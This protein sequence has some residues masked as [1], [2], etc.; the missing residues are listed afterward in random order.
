MLEI[1]MS[2]MPIWDRDELTKKIAGMSN[3]KLRIEYLIEQLVEH[4]NGKRYLVV[5]DDIW[6]EEVWDQVHGA[7]PENR[8]GSRIL[9]TSRIKAV[10]SHASRTPDPYPLP[11]LNQEES[12]KL[13]RKKVFGN[14]QCPSELDTYGRQ[15]AE[16]CR[17]LPLSIVVL[18]GI[19]ANRER[20][21]REWSRSVDNV[22]QYLNESDC[23]K[24]LALSYTHLPR[25]LKL[26]FLY[27]GVYPKDYEIPVRQ[28][29][30]L[31]LA[32][33]FIPQTDGGEMEAKAEDK[34]LEKFIDQN[35][36]QVVSRRTDGR[37][38]TCV[39]PDLLLDI[40]ISQCKE[41]MFLEVFEDT[42]LSFPNK[43]RR[44]SLQG[45]TRGCISSKHA[46][47][48][49]FF[50]PDTYS[51][52]SNHLKWAIEHLE[53]VRVLNFEE[54]KL[55]SIPTK[56]EKL[57]FLRYLRI[58]SDELKDLPASICNLENLETLDMRGSKFLTRLP[59]GIWKLRRLRNLYMYGAV[60]LPNHL[61][62]NITAMENLR[63]LSTISPNQEIVR[64]IS[65]GQIFPNLTKFGIWF[66]SSENH[67]EL[68][69][70]FNCLQGLRSLQTLKIINCSEYPIL[71]TFP[72]TI[73]KITLRQSCLNVRRD[74]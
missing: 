31:W 28:L 39:V 14:R 57:I 34:Y 13:L 68:V 46:R 6:T 17:G 60:S 22:N 51:S 27:L 58:K 63:V 40:C 20:S 61:D 54:V 25:D 47:S 30:Q 3:D 16:C 26:C 33:G 12:W 41:E 73:T 66:A 5:M 1:L 52:G 42:N 24:I 35:L 70:V 53:L 23:K 72:V 59:K 37:K 29:I 64:R 45:K 21:L 11:L 2:H 62:P 18:A 36:I 71:S 8:N 74:M 56:I 15:M 43:S 49:S 67:S 65:S 10:A 55:Y 50:G 32:E 44:L 38:K 4:L 9:I 69:E 48:L 19:L 7:F